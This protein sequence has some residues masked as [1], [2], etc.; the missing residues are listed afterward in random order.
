M[1]ASG[2]FG[3]GWLGT[4]L[5]V[6]ANDPRTAR[7][8]EADPGSAGACIE[9]CYNG[10]VFHLAGAPMLVTSMGLLGGGMHLW[11]K[12]R[13]ETGRG[14]RLSPRVA[15]G[16]GIGSLLAG[17]GALL[18]SQVSARYTSDPTQTVALIDIG[19]W[20]AG[21]FGLSGAALLGYGHG[22][23]RGYDRAPFNFAPT[24]S[25]NFMGLGVSGR[26]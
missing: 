16:V 24:V 22:L 13:G 4:K 15:M 18:L 12:W 14:S 23:R 21:I 20:S 17:G 9:S 1:V 7:E 19:W 3:L 11:G 5:V 2:F 25:R 10:F 26:F 8:I 6:T